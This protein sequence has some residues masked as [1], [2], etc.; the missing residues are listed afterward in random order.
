MKKIVC[1]RMGVFRGWRMYFLYLSN[2]IF[3]KKV[4]YLEE[5]LWKSIKEYD[6]I[7]VVIGGIMAKKKKR[8]VKNIIYDIIL[9]VAIVV[10]AFSA[11]KLGSIY[12]LNYLESKEKKGVQAIAKVP[13]DPEKDTFTIDWKTL[14]E[15]NPD[16]VA[17][18][19]IPDTEISYPIVQGKDN[20]FYLNRTFEKKENYA[21]AIFLDYQADKHFKD[22]NTL[23]YGHNVKHGTMFAELEK[24]KDESFFKAHPYVYIFTE[25]QNYR[26]EVF[27]M[28]SADANSDSYVVDYVDDKDY[29]RYVDMVQ[30]KSDFKTDVK[31]NEKDKMI[32][33]STCS[34][35]RSGQI[36]DD[37]YL[38]HAKLVPWDQPYKL[39]K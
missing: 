22:R 3:I 7:N 13:D 14:K 37:R 9:V 15:K 5:S 38:L 17:W 16:I 20:S 4:P 18:V 28:Y 12:Y 23:I 19:L 2:P 21:G 1:I 30:K 11:F 32:S 10:F 6:R 8:T 35:E 25:E 27:S 29:M 26:A 33:L 24:F 36:S 31:L 34:Y 39:N